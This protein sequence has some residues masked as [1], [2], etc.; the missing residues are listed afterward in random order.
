MGVSVTTARTNQNKVQ[1]IP[2]L[3]IQPGKKTVNQIAP[4]WECSGFSP[5]MFKI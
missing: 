3:A 5:Q 4:H 2:A 1:Q